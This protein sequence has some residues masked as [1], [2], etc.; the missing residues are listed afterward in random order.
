MWQI[1]MTADGDFCQVEQENRIHSKTK[2][3]LLMKSLQI[4]EFF[5]RI[6]NVMRLFL[7]DSFWLI[8]IEW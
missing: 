1:H 5:S 7:H 3:I 2:P 6:S 4:G 8:E